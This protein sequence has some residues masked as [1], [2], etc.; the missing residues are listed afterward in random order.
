MTELAELNA[1]QI[2]VAALIAKAQTDQQ[3]AAALHLSDRMVRVHI[4][5]I[6]F[7]I[8]ADP[9]C[10][11]RIQIALWYRERVPVSLTASLLVSSAF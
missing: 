9:S 1:K 6:A 11:T 4:T 2:A 5:A 10:N 8:G 7:L 3:I